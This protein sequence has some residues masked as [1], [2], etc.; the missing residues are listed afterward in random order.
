MT[1]QHPP[2]VRVRYA[3]HEQTI[4]RCGLLNLVEEFIHRLADALLS[5]D[6]SQSQ[7]R[8]GHEPAF[9]GD[10]VLNEI[11]LSSAVANPGP[12]FPSR[13]HEIEIVWN[14]RDEIVDIG[15]PVAVE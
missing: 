13:V 3:V 1:C 2:L 9:C 11:I 7:L 15:V 8:I 4:N 10:L 5:L 12:A 14:Q 6:L